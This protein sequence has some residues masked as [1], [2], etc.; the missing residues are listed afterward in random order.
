MD[1]EVIRLDIEK[2]IERLRQ[3]FKWTVRDRDKQKGL[4]S[5][6]Q[7][8]WIGFIQL[9]PNNYYSKIHYVF[10]HIFLLNEPATPALSYLFLSFSKISIE[11]LQPVANGVGLMKK[12][13]MLMTIIVGELMKWKIREMDKKVS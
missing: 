12:T 9:T 5:W 10:R 2:K 8:P 11:L 6:Q 13:M 7:T 3:P 1:Y 4:Y